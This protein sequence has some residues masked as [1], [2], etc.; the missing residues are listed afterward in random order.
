MAGRLTTHVLDLVHGRPAGGMT[1]QLW[2]LGPERSLCCEAITNQDGRCSDP[3]LADGD[4]QPGSY[5]LLFFVADYFRSKGLPLS[6]P[7]FLDRVPIH[8][9][10]AD[11]LGHY[12]VPLL[13]TPWAYQTYRGS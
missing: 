6:S 3:L 8:F 12:H 7:A 1:V 11:P 5:E 9:G 4:L 10:V 13:V 2:R